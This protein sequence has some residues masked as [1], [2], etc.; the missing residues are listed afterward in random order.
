MTFGEFRK[1]CAIAALQ[2]L[3][4]QDNSDSPFFW[5]KS[6]VNTGRLMEEVEAIV[7]AMVEWFG[8][9][10]DKA[11]PEVPGTPAGS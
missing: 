5:E 9:D 1:R 10:D 3:L 11:K 7:N 2:G 6:H 8:E 4:A